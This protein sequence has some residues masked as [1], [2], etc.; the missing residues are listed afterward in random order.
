MPVSRR[1]LLSR[2]FFYGTPVAGFGYAS[3]VEKRFLRLTEAEVPVASRHAALDGLKVGLVSDF[4][5]DDFGDARL[6]RRAVDSL[7]H[8]GADLV[9]LGGDYVSRDPSGLPLLCQ[10]L[11]RLRPRL[12]T[13]A[14]LGNHDR[15]HYDIATPEIFAEAGVRLLVNEAAVLDGFAVAG[16]DSIWG[17]R[18]DLG[19]ALGGV[20][21]ETPVLLAWHEPDTF[22]SYDDPR[23]ALQLSGHTHG[24]QVCA[25]FLG[26]IV[27]PA[28]GRR[29]PYG[30]YRRDE[31]SLFVTRG[32]GTVTLP[33]RFFCPPEAALLTLRARA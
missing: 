24:G 7:N 33:L 5:H 2:L 4:H 15:W 20:G 11:S 23:I 19:A 31:R 10:E 12:G 14:V 28:H 22:D 3:G 29:Y 17:G 21:P 13:Y 1:Y 25:P 26:P 6:V 9:I 30:L 18:P 8:R 16:P 27:L 32:I